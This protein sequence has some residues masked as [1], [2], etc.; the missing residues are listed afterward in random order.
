[1]SRGHPRATSAGPLPGYVPLTDRSPM[2]YARR[3][4]EQNSLHLSGEL[5]GLQRLSASLSADLDAEQ[6][7]HDLQR[8]LASAAT[9]LAAASRLRCIRK[10]IA[11]FEETP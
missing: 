2:G 11:M 4:A 6:T 7:V 1:M 5:A 10:T 9:A 8:I 3:D